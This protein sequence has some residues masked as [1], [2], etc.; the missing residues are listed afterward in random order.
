MSKITCYLVTGLS[1]AGKSHALQIFEDLGIACVDNLPGEL[2]QSF[3]EL[4]GQK[5]DESEVALILD[6]REEKFVEQFP[7]LLEYFT[8]KNDVQLKI[9]FLEAS[10]EE[11]LRRYQ[12]SRRPHPL[13]ENLDLEKAIEKE[14]KLLTSVRE[15]ADLILDTTRINI[16]QLKRLL[17]DIVSNSP[18]KNLILSLVSFGFKNGP[19]AHLDFMFDCRFLPN[20]YYE[21]ELK[22][23]TGLDKEIEDYFVENP[24]VN[25]YLNSVGDFLDPVIDS[26][27]TTDKL[28]ISVGLGC[29]GGRHRSVYLVEQLAKRFKGQR[30]L[31]IS[32]THR[33]LT[34]KESRGEEA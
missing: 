14:R 15:K 1:G 19:P 28:G 10:T 11:L 26:Y 31:N 16:H 23:K 9:L 30:F 7:E 22:E 12:E 17:A 8:D 29:T 32:V 20:P 2:V 24:E 25:I 27:H 33:D 18:Q 6:A 4:V 3:V 34:G 21:P 13:S 5:K